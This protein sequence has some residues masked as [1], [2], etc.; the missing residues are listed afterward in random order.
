MCDNLFLFRVFWRGLPVAPELEL[1][2]ITIRKMSSYTYLFSE[3]L[4]FCD[5][6]FRCFFQLLKRFT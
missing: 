6:Q 2:Y 3:L 5:E 4:V 1:V